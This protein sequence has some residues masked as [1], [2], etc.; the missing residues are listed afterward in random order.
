M[1]ERHWSTCERK[2][3]S[4]IWGDIT[5]GIGFQISKYLNQ[6]TTGTVHDTRVGR[7]ASGRAC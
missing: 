6:W 7:V 2:R 5:D 1:L 3:R 4:K